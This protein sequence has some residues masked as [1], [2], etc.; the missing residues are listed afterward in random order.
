MSRTLLWLLASLAFVS[1]TSLAD[2]A[3]LK[4]MSAPNLLRVGTA[5]NVF[6]ECQDCTGENILVNIN[7]MSHPTKTT[8]LT[9][10][11]VTL[12]SARN[13]QELGQITIPPGSFS[14]DPTIK[15][16]VYLQA[17][18]P[19]RLLEK[20]VL[21]SFQSG[22]IFIQTDK[23][24]YTPNSKVHYRMFAVTPRME[25][26]E[27]D[28]ETQT[29]A[30]ISIEIVTPEGIIL[31]LD[32]VSLKSGIHSGDFQLAEIVSLGLWKV[33]AKF[34][35]NPQQSYSADF[36][37][38]EYVLPSFEVKLMPVSSFFYVDS[39]ELTVNIKATYLF[40]QEVDGMAYV[41]FGFM[42]EGRKKSFPSSLQRVQI[43]EGV[44]VVKLKREH[45]TQTYPNILELVG[46]S[47]YVAASVLT[48]SGG[49]MVE[50]ELRSIQ[51]V[52]SPYTITFKKTPKYFK[53]GMSFDVTVEVVNPDGTPANGVAVVV[54]PGQVQALT[55][56]NGMSKLTI[57]TVAQSQTITART[58]D[59]RIS[60]E[61]QASATMVALP[62]TTQSNSYIHIGV[63]TAELELGDTLKVNLILKRK[64]NH[65]I[66]ITYLI[67]SRGQLVKNG[68]FKTR[69]QI[70]ISLTVTVTKEMLPSFRII[71]YYHTTSNE[72]VSD[73]VWVNVK[74]SCM[75]SL[76]LESSKPN[77]SY[78]PRKMFGLKVTGDP[79]ATVGLVAVD[80][81]VYVLNNNHRLNQKKVWDIVEK[82]DTGC[83]PGGGKDGMG[84]F[85]DAG[86]L[87]V[88]N[89]ASGTPYRQE[90]N[91]PVPSRRKRAA[92]IMDVTTSL[93]SQYQDQLQRD[94]CLDGMR[95]TPLSYTCERRSEYISDGADCA[96]AF[97]H[98]CKEMETLRA[99]RKEDS[100]ILAR[101]EEDDS[102]MDSNE[103]NSR[104]EF[105]E[106]WLWTDIKL[107]ACPQE[108]ANCD[109]TTFTK[110]V[111]LKDSITTWQF[112]GISLS[113]THGICVGEPLEVIVRKEF[114]I[115]L[116]LP[117]SAVRGEQLEIKAILHN[118][119]P[120]PATVRVDLTDEEHVCS[121]ASKRGRY[122]QEVKM[123]A[124]TT[125]AV[126]FI[127]IPMKEGKYSIEV[128]AAVKDSSLNDGIMK[129]LL[130]VPEGVLVKSPQIIILD[131]TTKGVGGRQEVTLNSEIPIKDLVQ[132]TPTST[133]ISVTGREQVS[134]LVENAVSGSSMGTLIVQPSGCGEQNIASM[135]LPVIAA[136][137]LDKT[138]QWETVGFQKR[139]E[140]LQHIK[141]G[142]QNELA[143][144]KND[145]SFAVWTGKESSTWLTA[146][147]AKVFAMA[148]N[149]VA[150]QS[151][152]ICEAIKFLIL[153]AQQP[154]GLFRESGFV[155]SNAM[156]SG[157]VQRES[158]ASMTAFCLIA[159]QE[160]RTICAASVNSL[161]AS[162]NK[163][164]AYLE[165]RLP[166]LTYSY[167]VAVT[168]YALA[169][170]N[171]LNK[172]ILYK[173]ASPDLSHWPVPTGHVY[174][175]EATAY[176][177]LALVKAE[178][179][180]EAR[181]IVR[182]FNT[183][184]KVGGGYGS[185]QATIIVYQ[186]IAEYWTSAKEPE[187]D[188]NVDILLPG[189]SKPDKYNFNRDNH[190]ATRT[191][192]IK[193]I[194]QNVKVTATGTGEATV[195][196]VS[197]YYALP[198]EKESDCQKFNLS[199][200]LLPEKMDEDEN[201]YK[202]RIEVLYK[203]KDSDASMSILDIGLL[204][205]F[206]VNT[207]DLDLLSKGRARIIARYEMN[208]VL[209][210]R[211]S[212][213]IYLDKVSHTRPEEITF[214]IHQ[215]M[216]VGV[217]QPAAVSVYEYYDQTHCVKFYHPER[218]AG[219]LLRLCTNDE[220]TC[221]EENC[222]MQNK[223]KISNDQRTAKV[224]ETTQTSI[225]DFVYKV[226]L[227]TFTED[228]S[229]DI[230]T[231]KVL[232]V[233]KEGSLDVGPLN[234]E[235]TFLS[236]P[237]CRESLDL[238]TG[239]TYL[240]MGTSKDIHRD[241]RHQSYQYVFG[242]RTWIEYWPTEAECQ[243][244]E[245]RI[246]CLG[247]EEMVQQYQLFGCQQ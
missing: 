33:V 93:V 25:P 57:N 49:E 32:P 119:S 151:Q 103:I 97:L 199:M 125:R 237:H 64:E 69:G 149:L 217:L 105:P 222:S 206:T 24:L 192:K 63:D 80:K 178:E 19:D 30:S 173:F 38:K 160:S 87:F 44:G 2:G 82:Y 9:S 187:Y 183:Q 116:R 202:L 73:S 6:V 209:S 66:D 236:Y 240:I 170:E 98:C 52:T 143:Y 89:T 134:A 231:V 47:I 137:Y 211:G 114:F 81:G 54:D 45:I 120:D 219:M 136:T 190:Y 111:P 246:T 90:L 59:D 37:V 133:Q 18:F 10:T 115:D 41:V 126:P 194:N 150:V 186:A 201:I 70:L 158:D 163:A 208:T 197:L 29:D 22:Y 77:P 128:K 245:H 127:I 203:D 131:P 99:E 5:E 161:P 92:T 129:K 238:R 239:K 113:R 1:L 75:G 51:I 214:R 4:V 167:A 171:K 34:Q 233:I 155:L 223:D 147:V 35:S 85:Y 174:T 83:T 154:D 229:T 242:E 3:P 226:R 31:P 61:R 58:K 179:F 15:Q 117:Y 244:E 224:C 95:N 16:Y 191:S 210:E 7:V 122:R 166:H 121:S 36:E 26:V 72:V 60:N 94:C 195:T 235:R 144:R 162:I 216:K 43:E 175:L 164:V 53:P 62:Y 130:V 153:K 185:T 8:K 180:E 156:R 27:R 139:S 17:Q 169:N 193:D 28:A 55:R 241:H 200:Q 101:S 213:I 78:E 106:S 227:E 74:D 118:H 165:R 109:A 68:R 79:G 152:H 182:W 76:R 181:P 96:A 88:S 198:K 91:C 65:D 71:A 86:L 56:A 159:M 168:S 50:A 14:K 205:G 146:Y 247:M 243:T 188:L 221:A 172:E 141:T 107:P 84:V 234:K 218:K 13:F 124:Q 132:N 12:T 46:S 220:C 138:N 176:A 148:N 104:T 102:Y 196:M 42:Q 67:L 207:D 112:T 145:G 228:L 189:R 39:Q 123:G 140:A 232:E 48:G 135:T 142:Y 40:G 110:N 21:V 225:I 204:T 100:L 230:F 157:V 184:Q 11:S 20:V 177:L 215:K 108:N 23:T 212:L